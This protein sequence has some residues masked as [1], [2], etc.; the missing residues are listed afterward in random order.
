[1]AINKCTV[2]SITQHAAAAS[3]TG[4]TTIS[5]DTGVYVDVSDIRE[6]KLVFL[7][8]RDNTTQAV[9][10]AIKASTLRNLYSDGTLGDLAV[11]VATGDTATRQQL[12]VIGPVETARFKDSSDRVKITC[13]GSTGALAVGVLLIA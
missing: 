5:T 10:L 11:T 9:S 13:T 4:L 6:D 2:D 3:L 1:M 12:L 8:K 7:I